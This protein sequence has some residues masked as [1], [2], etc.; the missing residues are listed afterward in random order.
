MVADQARTQKGL[1]NE[2]QALDVNLIGQYGSGKGTQASYLVREYGLA[3][4]SPGQALRSEIKAG[5]ELGLRAKAIV[6][7]GELVP[8]SIVKELLER[9][10]TK[11]KPGQ[12]IVADGLTRN[13]EQK[14]MF[15]EVSSEQG[16]HPVHVFIDV[17]KDTAFKR[18]STRKVCE[19][20][21]DAPVGNAKEEA[22][23]KKCGGKLAAR[24][25]DKP[26]LITKRLALY[27]TEIAPVVEAY[28][29]AGVLEEV[30]GEP[31]PDEVHRQIVAVLEQHGFS[32]SKH[33]EGT[34]DQP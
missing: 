11:L 19:G 5:T 7:A 24:H 6:E 2:Q 34:E 22:E 15:D 4:F 1:N 8:S 32:P 26:E 21:G 33:V 12:G 27:D 29:Q 20:C 14:G 17:S 9:A 10:L 13:F 23:C 31:G 25:D 16:R 18:L 3:H 28:R 30:D